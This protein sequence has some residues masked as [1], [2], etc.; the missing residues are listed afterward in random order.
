LLV[1]DDLPQPGNVHLDFNEVRSAK[2][3]KI[4]IVLQIRSVVAFDKS[5]PVDS[6]LTLQPTKA[7]IS[8]I[9]AWFRLL[10]SN[11]KPQVELIVVIQFSKI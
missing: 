11:S 9:T 4:S 7:Y 10:V 8:S 2:S 6:S 5:Q 1:N 3:N